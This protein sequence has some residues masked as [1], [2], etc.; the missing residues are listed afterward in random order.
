[1]NVFTAS[2]IAVYLFFV[3]APAALCQSTIK[4]RVTDASGSPAAYTNVLLIHAADSVLVKG[5]VADANGY[6]QLSSVVPGNYKL[7]LRLMGYRTSTIAP[8]AVKEAGGELNLGNVVLEE[9]TEHLEAV[10]VEAQK[11]LFEQQPDKLVINVQSSISAQG[12]TVLEVLE[13]S[14]GIAVNRQNGSLSMNGKEGVLVLINGKANRLPVSALVQM[15]SGMNAANIQKIELITSPPAKYDAE[16]DAGLIN[17]VLKEHEDAG[18]SG[19]LSITAGWGHAE[20]TGTSLSVNHRTKKLNVYGDYSYFRN[21]TSAIFDNYRIVNNSG[22]VTETYAKSLRNPVITNHNARLG[23][24]YTLGKRTVAGA[25]VSGYSNKWTMDAQNG[26]RISSNHQGTELIDMSIDE[27]NHW[28]HALANLNLVHQFSTS[29]SVSADLD[30]LYYY[31]DNPSDYQLLYAGAVGKPAESSTIRAGKKTPISIWVVRIDYTLKVGKDVKIEAGLKSAISRFTNDVAVR[32]LE[33]QLWIS[34]P[35][36]TN[37]YQ[38]REDVGAAYAQAS[39]QLAPGLDLAGGLRYEFTNTSLN[40]RTEK[41][42]VDR[43]WGNFFPSLSLA[44]NFN[45]YHKANISY[46]RRI[47]R[48]TFND[49]APFIIFMDPYTFFSG[50]ASLQPALTDAIK[51]D[52]GFKDKL[53]SL[54]YSYDDNAIASFQPSVDEDANTQ[55]FASQNL[56][57]KKTLALTLAVPV[58]PFK[59]WEIQNNLMLFHQNLSASYRQKEV[60]S[61]MFSYRINTT[62]NIRLPKH[63]SLEVSGF[64][65]SPALYGI[66][67]FNAYGAVNAGVQKKLANNNGTLSLSIRDIFWTYTWGGSMDMPEENLMGNFNYYYEPRDVR[68]SYTLNI[69]NRELKYARKRK[70]GSDEE[71]SRVSN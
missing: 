27:V 12:S 61:E 36:F 23:L 62:H 6:Y 56:N 29:Q 15:L 34:D 40:S 22:V 42:L 24:D 1:M 11:P 49:M 17:I 35:A 5:A 57:F 55:T 26:I 68:L 4:G 21:H 25:L 47:S 2:A 8:L 19:T 28:T 60:R 46:S 3:I 51:F 16:G 48:P 43:E 70:V 50:N 31:D 13:K 65:Q 45:V 32:R 44:K 69:G 67:K 66:A 59:F 39:A 71:R 9:D 18:T 7:S 38:L 58:A 37:V 41:G 53:L 54:Q 33:Q 10:V 64:Y 14:P 20:K 30:Y 63:F 52:Y